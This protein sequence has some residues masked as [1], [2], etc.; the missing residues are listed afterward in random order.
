MLKRI[1]GWR[2]K[3]LS[4]AAR[5]VLIKACLASIPV[6]LL[7]FIKFPKWAIRTIHTHMANC[8]WND[9][10]EAHKYH[11]VN[12]DTVSMLKEFGG[13]GVPNL[14]D[15]NYCLLA[16]WVRR[17]NVDE[18]KLWRQLIDYKY[19][20][21]RPNIFCSNTVGS[22]SFFK[23]MMAAATATKMG[24]RWKI[25][26]GRKVRFWEDNWI[27][28]SSLAIQFW[29]IYV[30]INEKSHS[31]FELWD[32][33]DLRCTFRRGV[34]NRLMLQWQEIIQLASTI[35]FSDEE[36]ALI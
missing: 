25:G 27:G 1:A 34:D 32:G 18:S 36:D 3:L 29:E 28:P 9:N 14:R 5:L 35:V 23:G 16:S 31:V 7:S 11:L 20:T 33:T 13:L 12:W 6:Y 19:N 26:N 24:Y 8:L 2:G 17:Y 10:L 15:L 21:D 4:Y 22:S 30:L